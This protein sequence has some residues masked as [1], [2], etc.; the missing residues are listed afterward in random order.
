MGAIIGFALERQPSVFEPTAV[1]V[2]GFYTGSFHHS[3]SVPFFCGWTFSI[4]MNPGTL[5]NTWCG[6]ISRP[7]M[8]AP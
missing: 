1:E 5:R 6:N 4:P 8:A 2:L 7:L 3:A